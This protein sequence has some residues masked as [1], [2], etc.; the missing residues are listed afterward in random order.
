MNFVRTPIKDIKLSF[1]AYDIDIDTSKNVRKFKKYGDYNIV[2][3]AESQTLLM[4]RDCQMELNFHKRWALFIQYIDDSSIVDI[5][6]YFT[7][8]WLDVFIPQVYPENLISV[9]GEDYIHFMYAEKGVLI[10]ELSLMIVISQIIAISG[11]NWLQHLSMFANL[12]YIELKKYSSDLEDSYFRTFLYVMHFLSKNLGYTGSFKKVLF[13]RITYKRRAPD[14]NEGVSFVYPTERRIDSSRANYFTDLVLILNYNIIEKQTKPYTMN[15]RKIEDFYFY[16]FEDVEMHFLPDDDACDHSLYRAGQLILNQISVDK[17]RAEEF[18]PIALV[19]ELPQLENV[20][21]ETLYDG[22]KNLDPLIN[23]INVDM[24]RSIK[25]EEY[26]DSEEMKLWLKNVHN[27]SKKNLSAFLHFCDVYR[28]RLLQNPEAHVYFI[29]CGKA[30]WYQTI[31]IMLYDRHITFIDREMTDW[32]LKKAPNVTCEYYYLKKVEP[33][34]ED[35][36]CI[37]DMALEYEDEDLLV[38]MKDIAAVSLCFMYKVR[39]NWFSEFWPWEL[40]GTD[41]YIPPFSHFG[42]AECRIYGSKYDHMKLFKIDHILKDKISRL[43]KFRRMYWKCHDCLIFDSL[44][45]KFLKLP[46]AWYLFT[47]RES[48]GDILK[49][50]VSYKCKHS[51]KKRN[52]YLGNCSSCVVKLHML[53]GEVNAQ[54]IGP[55]NLGPEYLNDRKKAYSGDVLEVDSDTRANI[56][57]VRCSKF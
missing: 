22:Q 44:I 36:I 38:L 12:D 19:T 31:P 37:M 20:K 8:N 10:N 6:M 7:K 28:E 42:S 48:D 4:I 35:A 30:S 34:F 9:Y 18:S 53:V 32:K 21:I 49:H 13:N 25:K 55:A 40:Y 51:V 29:G 43:T 15:A 41:I 16:C 56:K 17:V 24:P 23:I 54:W 27:G 2:D 45:K 46:E 5:P 14:N 26:N 39:S 52:A 1:D 57:A 47:Q 3:F 11:I 33:R 50:V